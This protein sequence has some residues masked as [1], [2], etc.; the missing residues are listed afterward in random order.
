[1]P[2]NIKIIAKSPQKILFVIFAVVVIVSM[3]FSIQTLKKNHTVNKT[4]ANEISL[5]C[6]PVSWNNRRKMDFPDGIDSINSINH[7]MQPNKILRQAVLSS[8]GN[9]LYFRSLTWVDNKENDREWKDMSVWTDATETD[10]P[11][12]G[13]SYRSFDEVVFP[14]HELKQTLLTASGKTIIFR[15]LR[16]QNNR[17][18]ESEDWSERASDLP[19]DSTAYLSYDHTMLPDGRLKQTV[20]SEDGKTLFVRY[21]TSKCICLNV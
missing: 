21:L 6:P 8:E 3:F 17:W 19:P 14:N 1:M 13:G 4:K 15:Y 11:T 10:L 12:N 7:V 5:S 20:L 9:R 18:V 2:L 16:W